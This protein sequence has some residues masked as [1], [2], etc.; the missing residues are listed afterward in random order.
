ME[1]TTSGEFSRASS[2]IVGAA[3][4]SRWEQKQTET[5][6]TRITNLI[7]SS[8]AHMDDTV[9]WYVQ[10]NPRTREGIPQVLRTAI[11]LSR[12]SD[13]KFL[14]S[15]KIETD[16]TGFDLER[17]LRR[18]PVDDPVIFD[19]HMPPFGSGTEL[20]DSSALGK[21]DMTAIPVIN[22]KTVI[23]DEQLQEPLNEL[24]TGTDFAQKHD[25]TDYALEAA[26]SVTEAQEAFY[27]NLWGKEAKNSGKESERNLSTDIPEFAGILS[28]KFDQVV[29]IELLEDYFA[30]FKE[31][32]EVKVGIR[33]DPGYTFPR[34]STTD[35]ENSWKMPKPRSSIPKT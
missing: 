14:M 11:L 12:D 18:Q 8:G 7:G 33:L 17:A 34:C 20:I 24:K 29:N 4:A 6:F 9:D 25:T 23:R 32:R 28:K 1:D 19:P 35:H 16:I 22:P 5:S 2:G 15:I 27:L 3:I 21:Y 31:G 10:E 26:G 30:W 13:E